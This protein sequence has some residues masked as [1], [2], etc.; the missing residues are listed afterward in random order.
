MNAAA[1]AVPWYSDDT[2]TIYHGDSLERLRALPDNSVDS[3]VTDP[4][5]GLA[6]LPA[7]KVTD[8][9]LKW[10]TGDREYIPGGRGFMGAHWDRFVP[11]PALWDEAFRVLKPGGYLLSFAGARTQD[12]MGMSIRLAGFVLKD[13]LQWL[14]ADSFNK[15]KFV[16]KSG[17]E[18]ILM[19]QKPVEG[20]ILAN[21]AEHGTGGLNI[22]ATRTA[23]RSAADEA[24]TK[25]KN[26]HNTYGTGQGQYGVYGDFS[27]LETRKNYDAPG[28]WPMN[29]LL[30][31]ITAR[32]IDAANPK[33]KSHSSVPRSGAAGDGWGMQS[34]GAE[35]DDEGGPSRF[36]PMF[37][38]DPQP[39]FYAGRAR[40]DE[41]P[42]VDGVKHTTV[43]PISV[44][45]WLITLVTP[46]GGTVL[47]PFLGSGTTAEAARN[48][49]YRFIG[50]EG[51][52]PYLPLI[53]VRLDRSR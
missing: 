30:D 36:Y 3:I 34:G 38:E 9:L 42:V 26:Q 37:A 2:A 39:H 17:Y 4:P 49:G 47:D 8:A 5:Y 41:R 12:L 11:P 44:M 1:P 15:S 7:K 18:P 19:A 52:A 48:G 28:R 50:V 45:T 6:D 29:V 43:K 33:S 21:I 27:A 53:Q 46:V 20:T 22:D 51:H 23:F 32:D 40:P 16:L 14:K 13:N 10:M 35:Y 31:E 24:E 25:G